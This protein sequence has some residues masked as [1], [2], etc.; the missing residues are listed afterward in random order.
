MYPLISLFYCLYIYRV[1]YIKFIF[2][3]YLDTSYELKFNPYS[4]VGDPYEWS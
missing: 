4:L 2:N 1:K 3:S